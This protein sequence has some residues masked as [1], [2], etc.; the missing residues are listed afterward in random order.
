MSQSEVRIQM[1]LG[2]A[3]QLT[4]KEVEEVSDFVSTVVERVMQE[5]HDATA[6]FNPNT[7]EPCYA[8]IRLPLTMEARVA[9][10]IGRLSVSS[11]TAMYHQVGVA[12]MLAIEEQEQQIRFA[13]INF[14]VENTNDD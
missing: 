5:D 10:N 13:E 6:I 2:N 7:G 12:T 1:S 9:A 14:T 3:D 8:T 11:P 4:P